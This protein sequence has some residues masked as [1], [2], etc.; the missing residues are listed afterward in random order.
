MEDLQL[1]I[2]DL[3]KDSVFIEFVKKNLT[4]LLSNRR[5]RP[6]SKLGYRYKRDWYDKM[7]GMLTSDFFIDNI[8]DIWLKKSGL[9]SEFRGVI[10][11][12]CDK[13]LSETLLNK[14]K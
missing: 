10:K 6:E 12:V 13:A 3:I 4:E 2:S 9:N 14:Q 5:T 1:N 7:C 8:G 11:Y